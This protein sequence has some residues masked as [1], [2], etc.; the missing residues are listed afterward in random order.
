MPDRALY[1]PEWHISDPL[2]L[3]E[4]L[5]YWDQMACIVPEQNFRHT[6]Y[7]DDPDLRRV[8]DE[9]HEYFVYPFVPS[10]EQKDR[11]HERIKDFAA[12]TPP[13]WCRPENLIP[14]HREVVSGYKLSHKTVELLQEHGWAQHIKGKKFDMQLISSAAADIVIGALADECGSPTMPPITDDPGS[15]TANCNLLL[16]ELGAPTGFTARKG[17]SSQ[18]QETEETEFNFL[19]A[20]VPRL[21]LSAKSVNANLLRTILAARRNADLDAQRKAFRAKIDDYV[22]QLRKADEQER[23]MIRDHFE[24]SV[25]SDTKALE[26]ELRRF[27]LESL[28]SKEGAV[29]I[30]VGV[31]FGA[32]NPGLGLVLALGATSVN[33]HN[34]RREVV[35]KH[36]SSWIFSATPHR[37]SIW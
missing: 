21:G 14:E 33:Y 30:L 18:R 34:K 6:P 36:W 4:S 9:I 29:A 16:T 28:Y 37:I 11:V 23:A 7:F 19:L 15:F 20:N 2:F 26:N 13:D 27:G 31:I 1:Y 5:L 25:Q 3:A 10:K 24:R 22:Q 8:V 32:V 12:Q 17:Q 35:A